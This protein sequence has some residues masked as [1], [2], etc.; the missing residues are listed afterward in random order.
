MDDRARRFVDAAVFRRWATREQVE[1]CLRI[2]ETAREV[3]VEQK[4]EEIFVKKGFLTPEQVRSIL[5][6]LGRR[7]IGKYRLIEKIG[8]GGAGTVY[9]AEQEPLGRI[10]AVKVLSDRF[11]SSEKQVKHF[12]REARV[13]VTLNHEN[14][15]KGIDYGEADGYHF[16]AMELVE[17]ESLFDLLEREG[18]LEERRAFEIALQTSHALKHAALFHL[19]HRDVKPKNIVITDEEVVKLCDLGLARPTL[20]RADDKSKAGPVLGTPAYVSPEQIRHEGQLDFRSDVY[21][22]GATL[23]HMVTGRP[24][25]LGATP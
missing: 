18:V 5:Q 6:E 9:R 16:F 15:V 17:G 3:G 21:S 20:V 1:E 8:E 25:F 23:Y 24:P 12:L 11:V 2:Q 14:I 10:V 7:R 4:L 22:L 19:V 13:A